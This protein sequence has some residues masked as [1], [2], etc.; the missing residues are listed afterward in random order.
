VRT[1]AFS[2]LV[3]VIL[4]GLLG[5]ARVLLDRQHLAWCTASQALHSFVCALCFV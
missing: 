5:G 1:Y 4:Q 2:I 3:A